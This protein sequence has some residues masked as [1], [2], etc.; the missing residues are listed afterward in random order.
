MVV[1]LH[2]DFYLTSVAEVD[3][4]TS[5][6]S[7]AARGAVTT[8]NIMPA[9][10]ILGAQWGDEGKG[11]LVDRLAEQATWVARFQGGN[12]AGHTVVLGEQ[13]LKFHL[14]PSGITRK[15]CHLV[16]GDGMVIDPWVLHKELTDWQATAGEDPRGDRLYVSERAHIILPY[17]R[18]MDSLD[19][20]IGTTGRGIGPTYADKI[21]RV[22]LR[23]GDVAEVLGDADWTNATVARMNASLE[24]AGSTERVSAD[25]L[26][27]DIAWIH[28]NYAS[29]IANTGLMLDNALK[30]GE[31]V[32]L[33]G[34]QGTLLDIDQGTFPFVTSSITSR[35]N[36]THG[37]GIHPG[38]VEDV[39]GITKAYITRVGHGAM[40]T[41]LDDEAGEH[42]G[43][44]GKEFGTTTGRKRRCGWF[45]A[46]VMR[47][48]Q[49]INGFTGLALT[50][51]D[52]LGG[53][54]E[55]KIC[56]AYELD[57]KEI[58]EIPSTA[59]ALARCKPV[60][61]TMPGFPELPL[62]EWL[63]MAVHANESGKGIAVLP[64]AAQQYIAKL[65][66]LVGVPCTSVG[67]GPDRDATID[68]V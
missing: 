16:L 47:Q 22:G 50:K 45:D 38:H 65:E 13:V 5:Q 41:E 49:R 23:F 57:G 56:V 4:W 19:T 35:G 55:L 64:A 8:E 68:C 42:M 48:A 54:D 58:T 27:S 25:G 43:T 61:I 44:V 39:I 51:L 31:H 7:K 10:V 20:K 24:A 12:N 6:G 52:V 37:A 34:A 66:A 11:K 62:S 36:A 14:L 63:A 32:I 3:A 28:E 1:H 46:V 15:E 2:A 33:E 29:C 40:P 53:L 9:T 30:L 26:A 59:S 17:H 67:V 60:Y 21:N 18:Y